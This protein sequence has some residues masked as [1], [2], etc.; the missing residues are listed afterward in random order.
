VT[1]TYETILYAEDGRIGTLILSCPEDGN[2]FTSTICHE[3]CD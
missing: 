1:T 3:P 2:L